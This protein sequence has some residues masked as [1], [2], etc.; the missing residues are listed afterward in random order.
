MSRNNS[1]RSGSRSIILVASRSPAFVEIVSDMV[2]DNGFEVVTPADAEPAWLSVTRTQPVLVICDCV[3][4]SG[5]VK[6]LIAEVVSRQLP[7]LMLGTTDEQEA[8]RVE[9]LPHFIR[10]LQFPLARDVFQTAI[11][12]LL[13][14]AHDSGERVVLSGAGAATEAVVCDE[15]RSGHP[16]REDGVGTIEG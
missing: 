1:Q 14:P 16:A 6:R 8:T 7:L 5:N 4:P 15:L 3:E 10:W 9:S 11:A 2:I 13:K 12:T